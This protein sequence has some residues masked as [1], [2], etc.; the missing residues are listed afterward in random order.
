M[1]GNRNAIIEGRGRAVS[2]LLDEGQGPLGVLGGIEGN[3]VV[4]T[5]AAFLLMAF[6]LEGRVF[7]LDLGGVHKDDRQEIGGG[8]SRQDRSRKS[9]ADKPGDEAAVVEVGMGQKQKVY[10]IRRTGKDSNSFP[11]GAFLVKAA[12]HEN[13]QSPAVR[14]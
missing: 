6:F 9:V 14:A 10:F 1:E 8:R 5:A 2:D 3:L 13:V 11:E 12:I 4:G 7:F